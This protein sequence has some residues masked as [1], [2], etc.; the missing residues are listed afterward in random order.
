MAILRVANSKKTLYGLKQASRKWYEKLSDLLISF[1]YKQSHANHSLFI[2][3]DGD[4][5]T[6]LLIY[7]DDIVLTGNF[8]AEMAQI[9]YVLHSNFRVKDLGA[10]KYFLGLE[11]NHFADGMYVSQRKYCLKLLADSGM[12]GCKPCSMPMDSSLWLCQNDSSDLLDEPLSYMRLV[13]RLIYLTTTCPD[14]VCATQ[15]LSQFMAHPTKSHLSATR[16]VL[17]YL[18]GFPSK[19]LQFKRDTLIHLIG[20]SNADWG[21]CVDTR[22]SS[23]GYCFFI[24]NSLVSWKTKKQSTV[25]RSSSEAEYRALATSTCEL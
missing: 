23:T 19:G 10:L 17:R 9:K 21:T 14:I 7:V 18:K 8:A 2:K 22:R 4:K 1:S 20:F 3:H 6:A 15:Q 12:L 16:R 24:G 25:S 13:G 5:F 11:I